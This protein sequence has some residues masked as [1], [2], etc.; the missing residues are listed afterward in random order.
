MEWINDNLVL[1]L[2]LAGAAIALAVSLTTTIS[3]R[4]SARVLAILIVLGSL[5]VVA[6]QLITASLDAQSERDRMAAEAARESIIKE[7]RGTVNRT[8]DL[9]TDINER[10][11]DQDLSALGVQLVSTRA[12]PA[13]CSAW[14]RLSPRQS[15]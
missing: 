3:K 6:Q 13:R 4:P 5:V 11:G 12:T 15:R 14:S 9:V 7:I 2:G 1:V 8:E 10:I